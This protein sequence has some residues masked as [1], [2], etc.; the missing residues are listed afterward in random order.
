[1]SL[2]DKAEQIRLDLRS[3]QEDLRGISPKAEI[4]A[5]IS[6]KIKVLKARLACVGDERVR[7]K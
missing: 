4:Y 6:A 1:M 2:T 3:L 5:K 7:V